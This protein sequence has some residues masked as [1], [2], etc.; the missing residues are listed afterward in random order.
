[1]VGVFSKQVGHKI[2]PYSKIRE[3]LNEHKI[4]VDLWHNRD[5]YRKAGI[6][7]PDK[8]QYNE[9]IITKPK[10]NTLFIIDEEYWKSMGQ[11]DEV[12]AKM[13]QV[14]PHSEINVFALE[15]NLQVVVL[16]KGGKFYHASY[17][18]NL[19]KFVAT[20]NALTIKEVLRG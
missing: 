13:Y 5:F 4:G 9:V 18:K 15:Y 3:K 7:N 17:D 1:M 19:K 11:L 16:G 12:E 8:M 6:N 10:S 14:P 20:N 2:M